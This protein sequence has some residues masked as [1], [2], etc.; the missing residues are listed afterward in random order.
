MPTSGGPG[1]PLLQSSTLS[2]RNIMAA[3]LQTAGKIVKH[4][5]LVS[6]WKFLNMLTAKQFLTAA[7]DL[8]EI[9]LGSLASLQTVGRPTIVFIKKVPSEAEEVLDSNPDL[10]TVRYYAT[11]FSMPNSKYI[12][13]TLQDKLVASG[14]VPAAWFE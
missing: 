8:Q 2:R 11:R 7:S 1:G 4:K 10:C 3:I 9:G 14:L 13:V 12:S 6:N 5:M